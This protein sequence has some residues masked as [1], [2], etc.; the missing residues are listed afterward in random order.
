MVK[1]EMAFLKENILLRRKPERTFCS[2]KLLAML[3]ANRV[4]FLFQTFLFFSAQKETQKVNWP[5]AKMSSI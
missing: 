4:M 5:L 3:S 2:S 1:N